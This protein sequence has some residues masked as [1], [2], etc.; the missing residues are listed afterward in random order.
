VAKNF[1]N[2]SMFG[3]VLDGGKST[4]M[5]TDKGS[6]AYHGKPQ[7]NYLMDLLKPYCKEVY[8]SWS[9]RTKPPQNIH[10]PVIHDNF[11]DLGGP[12]NGILSAFEFN[13]NVSWLTVPVDMPLINTDTIAYLIQH[14][15]KQKLATCFQLH[16]KP[17]PLFAIWES[18][19]AEW[20]MKFYKQNG[21]SPMQ[22]LLQ[23][24]VK[25]LQP[26]YPKVLQNINTAEAL[27]AYF[28]R[29]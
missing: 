13:S 1:M 5:G 18:L 17:E 28:N 14:R 20:L 19:A 6:I 21:Q 9:S 24:P 26:P 8:L 11:K 10:Y 2:D 3:L 15:D 7:R 22:F 4:R 25:M 12:L 16:N 29:E 27:T 23:H